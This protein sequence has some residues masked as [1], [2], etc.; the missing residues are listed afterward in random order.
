[1]SF[2]RGLISLSFLMSELIINYNGIKEQLQNG[3]I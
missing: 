2:N 3:F 1:M